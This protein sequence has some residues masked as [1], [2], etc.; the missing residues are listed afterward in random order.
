MQTKL[1][2]LIK[3]KK[4]DLEPFNYYLSFQTDFKK[5]GI[6]RMNAAKEEVLPVFLTRVIG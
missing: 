6:L 1:R 2:M 3:K 4:S 5:P